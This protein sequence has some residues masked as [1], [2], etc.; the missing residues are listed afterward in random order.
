VYV[1]PVL[2]TP[3][4][5]R[6]DTLLCVGDTGTYTVTDTNSAQIRYSVTG[7]V[8][9][10]S[11]TGHVSNVDSDFTVTAIATGFLGCG[12]DTISRTVRVPIIGS[13]TPPAPQI[14][15]GDTAVT[16]VFDSIFAGTGGNQIEW[17]TN[18]G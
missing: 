7:G 5:T 13:P 18:S 15:C 9:I 8:S 4:F 16:Y 3:I 1:A 14:T 12:S 10:D 11:L 2:G 17:A 6:G